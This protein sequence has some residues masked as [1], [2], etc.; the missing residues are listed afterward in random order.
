[1]RVLITCGP[2]W[3]PLDAVRVISNRSTGEMG[4]VLAKAFLKRKARVTLVEGPMAFDELKAVLRQKA[5]GHDIIVHAAAVSD[6]KTASPLKAKLSS[7]KPLTLRLVPTEKLINSIKRWS[8]RALLVG[9]KLEPG[10]T[11]ANAFR[12]AR[13]LFERA[14]CDLVVANTVSRG[15]KGFIVDADGNILGKADSKH[16]AA[17][18]LAKLLL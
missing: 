11:S 15:Y 14:K 10:L 3:V 9:F 2:I 7:G 8:P 4:R 6:F 13:E 18:A 12:H 16:K 17:E 1:M 5:K